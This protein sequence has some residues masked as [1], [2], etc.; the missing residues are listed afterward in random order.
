[1]WLQ[2]L[3]LNTEAWKS[4]E[5]QASL[6]PGYPG[7]PF[8]SRQER[9]NINEKDI[10]KLLNPSATIRNNILH[11]LTKLSN[12]KQDTMILLKHEQL[13]EKENPLCCIWCH[14][15]I[16]NS[17]LQSFIYK[18][19]IDVLI[20]LMQLLSKSIQSFLIFLLLLFL[21]CKEQKCLVSNLGTH[22]GLGQS[23]VLTSC[24]SLVN[25]F[26]RCSNLVYVNYIWP[27]KSWLPVLMG[28]L[29]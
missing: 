18:H 3:P 21:N 17:Q 7:L 20:F 28:V 12:D 9:K 25:G 23:Y 14:C 29:G 24:S 22:L 19:G 26:L 15:V 27:V 16:S 1:M 5:P 4:G 2:N 8:P 10:T 11:I 6:C 13:P